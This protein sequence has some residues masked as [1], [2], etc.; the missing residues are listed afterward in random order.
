ML[1]EQKYQR[2]FIWYPSLPE[3]AT[4]CALKVCEVCARWFAYEPT[5]V[6]V[7]TE[8]YREPITCNEC[9]VRMMTEAISD[10]QHGAQGDASIRR[11]RNEEQIKYR[12]PKMNQTA[13]ATPSAQRARRKHAEWQIALLKAF[14]EKHELLAADIKRVTQLSSPI[15][16]IISMARMHEIP[17]VT[18]RFER[19][20]V[21]HGKKGYAV[22]GL[23]RTQDFTE[24]GSM[25]MTN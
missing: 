5:G 25:E 6:E 7:L 18:L 4:R 16:V 21:Q 1:L 24:Y 9:H 11:A 10:I 12:K 17:I 2:G 19:K 14:E 22:Y 3:G 23:L 20:D 8:Q 15:S 13:S